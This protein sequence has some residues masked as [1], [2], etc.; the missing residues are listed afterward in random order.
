MRVALFGTGW[1]MKFHARAVL[2]HPDAEL[3]AA[4]VDRATQEAE[5]G[6]N[7]EH[8]QG[9]YKGFPEVELPQEPQT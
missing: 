3:V 8:P 2:E 9:D 6:E 4:L 5:H 1:I 7:R